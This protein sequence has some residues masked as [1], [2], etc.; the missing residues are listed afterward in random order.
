LADRARRLHE[1]AARSP[2][3]MHVTAGIDALAA[4]GAELP[5]PTRSTGGPSL[6][7]SARGP[8]PGRLFAP[9]RRGP[10]TTTAALIDRYTAIGRS[11][12]TPVGVIGLRFG[13]HRKPGRTGRFLGSGNGADLLSELQTPSRLPAFL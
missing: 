8:P 7:A 2:D 13:F 10:A 4:R 3:D 5:L 11:Y 1:R 6:S 12:W 9:W